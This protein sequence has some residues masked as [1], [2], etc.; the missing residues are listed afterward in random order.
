MHTLLN[1]RSREL[2]GLKPIDP[3]WQCYR[4]DDLL[5]YYSHNVLHKVLCKVR[6]NPY[7]YL[8][9]K[10][11]KDEFI[12]EYDADLPLNP[13]LEIVPSRGKPQAVSFQ[14]LSRLRSNKQPLLRLNLSHKTLVSECGVKWLPSLSFA[15]L[16][17]LNEDIEQQV[18]EK[19]GDKIWKN[20]VKT[21]LKSPKTRQS[22][23]EGDI[24]CVNVGPNLFAYGLL[25]GSLMHLRKTARWQQLPEMHY[26]TSWMTVPI[27][28]RKFNLLSARNDLTVE[29]V[30]QH[31]LLAAEYSM[32]DQL[33][34]G[35][36]KI[37][38][39]KHLVPEDVDFPLSFSAF[40]KHTGSGYA[41]FAGMDLSGHNA[42]LNHE[43][44]EYFASINA[45]VFITLEWG[46]ASLR[47]SLK[48]YLTLVDADFNFAPRLGIGGGFMG[49]DPRESKPITHSLEQFGEA[50]LRH[51][52]SLAA[53]PC[54]AQIDQFNSQYNGLTR[55][56]YLDYIAQN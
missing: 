51:L 21:L 18:A 7:S 20:K 43:K 36:F 14:Y 52:L 31:A 45:Q 46:F 12:I 2:L 17:T 4:S 35:Q 10:Q 50:K 24:F 41:S 27:I 40:K 55:Q 5:F 47:W 6:D 23:K 48:D 56:E 13:Q 26:M 15:S 19:F 53:Q 54:E 28:Y 1:N 8:E 30:C 3:D 34:R 44:L 25:I 37:I 29:Q 9:F 33:M 16:A 38:G 39:Q 42:Q 11:D 49:V 22:Y 32:D